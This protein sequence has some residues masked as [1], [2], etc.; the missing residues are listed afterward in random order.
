MAEFIHLEDLALD[1]VLAIAGWDAQV[2]QQALN[3]DNIV[4]GEI[5]AAI[6]NIA[7]LISLSL[8]AEI[9]NRINNDNRIENELTNEINQTRAASFTQFISN[10][11]R[12]ANEETKRAN[13]DNKHANDLSRFVT[14]VAAQSMI[15]S[16]GTFNFIF[17]NIYK[18]I[19]GTN[20]N[21]DDMQKQFG[22]FINEPINIILGV[23]F[24]VIVAFLIDEITIGLTPANKPTPPRVNYVS[25]ANS[26]FLSLINNPDVQTENILE[27]L[28]SS[29]TFWQPVN[30]SHRDNISG[31]YPITQYTTK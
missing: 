27:T 22:G 15:G 2:L 6:N 26:K 19:N 7:R 28:L 3:N 14:D 21:I 30:N 13:E 17:S 31:V 11:N 20:D 5:S 8:Q 12:L 18:A 16:L 10:L 24:E 9:N 25:I 4:R 23:V 29:A 1:V